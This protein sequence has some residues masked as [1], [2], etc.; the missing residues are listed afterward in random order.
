ML[1]KAGLSRPSD[2]VPAAPVMRDERE[3]PGDPLQIHT[4]KLAVIV[5]ASHR[6]IRNR[7]NLVDGAG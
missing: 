4:K 2:Q 3:A 1:A 6:V 7:K 5:R